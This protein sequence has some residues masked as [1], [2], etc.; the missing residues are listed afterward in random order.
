MKGLVV[1]LLSAVSLMFSSCL[2]CNACFVTY[3]SCD[4]DH[5]DGRCDDCGSSYAQQITDDL[6]LCNNC[7][8]D[9]GDMSGCGGCYF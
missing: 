2:G 8:G 1:S 5:A 7:V 4:A 9:Y 6:E 3:E